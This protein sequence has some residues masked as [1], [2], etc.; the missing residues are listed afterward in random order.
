MNINKTTGYI[1]AKFITFT[2]IKALMLGRASG[3]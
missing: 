2:A 3:L 1:A